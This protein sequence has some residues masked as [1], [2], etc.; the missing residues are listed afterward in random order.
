[1]DLSLKAKIS[2]ATAAI[3]FPAFLLMGWW[4]GKEIDKYVALEASKGL[5]NFVDAKQQGVIRYMAQNRKLADT[6][7]T[8]ADAAPNDVVRNLFSTLVKTDV[9]D[10]EDHKYKQEIIAGKRKIP[11][12]NVYYRIDLIRDGVIAVSS[13]PA[14]EKKPSLIDPASVKN[15]YTSVYKVGNQ[16]WQTFA[17]GDSKKGVLIH[18]NGRML[19]NIVSGEIGNLEKGMSYYYLAG[20]GRTFDYYLT[21]ATNKLIT[22]SRVKGEQALLTATGSMVPWQI[23]TGQS[24]LVDCKDGVYVTNTGATTFCRETMGFYTGDG[25][26]RMIGASMPFYDSSWTIVVEQQADE[27]FAPFEQLKQKLLFVLVAVSIL[28]FVLIQAL[29]GRF[30]KQSLRIKF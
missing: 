18:T 7:L 12:L 16:Y 13:D 3:I 10:I 1:M 22:G 27:L 15:G 24:K 21:D 17:A 14:V 11:A 30:V 5:M 9:F 4:A 23:S 26:K 29:I 25:G 8:T 19:E 6:F 2:A 28:T 20:V